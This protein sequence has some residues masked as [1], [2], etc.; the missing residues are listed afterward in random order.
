MKTKLLLIVILTLVF[1]EFTAQTRGTRFSRDEVINR[2]WTYVLEKTN[3]SPEDA[4]KVEP[5]FRETEQELWDMLERN[6][7]VFRNNR[8]R[9]GV[10]TPDFEA[11]NEAMVNFEVDNAQIQ[12][13][14]YLKLKK[15]VNPQTINQLLNAER[16]YKR[17]LTQRMQGQ[18]KGPNPR[19]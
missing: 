1:G 14:Y 5:I 10:E 7:E 12:R 6:R 13:K 11:I 2:K 8:R 18:Q 19:E 17:E 9:G 15:V 3:L 16:A 4:A